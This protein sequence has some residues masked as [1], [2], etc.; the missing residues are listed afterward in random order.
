M[1]PAATKL[2]RRSS[3]IPRTLQCT[4][5]GLS[6]YYYSRRHSTRIKSK[7]L[8]MELDA[9]G[10]W[11]P[12]AALWFCCFMVAPIAYVYIM[13][14]LLRDLCMSFPE[15]V[16]EPL[17][18]YVPWLARLAD[19]M[20]GASRIMDVWCV[21][22]ALF[23]IFCKLKIQYLQR[24]DPLEA[25]LSAAPMMDPE[26]R[27]ELWDRM[28]VSEE[29]PAAFI[30]GWFF[31]QPIAEISRYDVMD[32]V[33]WSMF[34]GRN[35]E[36]LTTEELHELEGFLEEL[37]YKISLSLYGQRPENDSAESLPVEGADGGDNSVD[38][39]QSRDRAQSIDDSTRASASVSEFTGSF[40][41]RPRP[42]K[43]FRFAVD[44]QREEPT[45]FSNLYESYKQSYEKYRHIVDSPNFH[46]VQD[47]RNILAETAQQAEESAT[48]TAQIMYE[49]IVQP[50]SQLD[51]QL[52]ALSQATSL[53]LTEAWNSMK[54]VKERVETA[55]F[56][57]E[58]RNALMEQ[59]R[60]NRAMLARM[61]EMSYAVPSK[62]MAALL[63][64]I[65]ECYDALESV[66]MRAKE[67]FIKATGT[68]ADRG[69]SFFTQP[70]PQRYAKYSS[71]PLLGIATYPLG[72]HLFVLGASEIPVRTMFRYNG[73]ERRC[74]G[75]ITYYYH[76][77][78]VTED[79]RPPQEKLPIVFI[80]GIGIGLV[81]Y[82]QLINDL[83]KTCRPILVPD[84]PYVSGFR[85]WQSTNS[86]L[87]PAVV[88]S[89]LTAMLA[90]HA[91]PKAIFTGHSY[92][93]SWLSYMCKYSP[94][95]VAALLFLDPI[96]FCLNSSGLTK[97][98][99]YHRADPGTIS[100]MI[101]TDM[102]VNWTIQ[103]A[104]PWAWVA[105]F[106]E[107]VNV[108][109]TVFLSDKDALVPVPRLEQ[110]FQ[111]KDIPMCDAETVDEKFFETSGD[112]SCCVYRGHL[113]GAFTEDWSL[114][115]PISIA[116]KS[117]CDK[118]DGG[119]K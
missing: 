102:I 14:M 103:R 51:K 35:Q 70:Q 83:L 63:R 74:I 50:G 22:E 80:H 38:Q 64:R 25:S 105:L 32:F 24:K 59:L 8:P 77:G 119:A 39:A 118:V 62:Q 100:F 28:M 48:A 29:D 6:Q 114:L 87:S 93:T 44:T 79:G 9:V 30:S 42:N 55:T 13:L 58:Q 66:E 89:T 3:K 107:Q 67:G 16:Y 4:D 5:P 21:I 82:V 17:K 115:P 65:T 52:S 49:T 47:F 110:Y 56:L 23:F 11:S 36:H 61:R 41:R 112:F 40:S 33:C 10:L 43:M 90:T 37:E 54:G 94:S 72:F 73:F 86:V 85:P 78:S 27:R 111:S 96:C 19:F 101:R 2:R 117:L 106:I 18:L 53:Q 31:D 98:F 92:G 20:K 76:H 46:P 109:C 69:N 116:C 91:Y 75:P 7:D 95:V 71:D 60:G 15:T 1:Q 26:D 68:L 45:F 34:D 12:W 104:F 88:A 57:S 113:H 108:P 84:I 97:N 99:V 81:S